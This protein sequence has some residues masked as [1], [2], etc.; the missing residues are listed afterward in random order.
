VKTT[1][2]LKSYLDLELTLDESHFLIV[3]PDL[4]VFKDPS[5]FLEQNS[6]FLLL[7]MN[8]AVHPLSNAHGESNVTGPGQTGSGA[9]LDGMMQGWWRS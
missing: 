5:P 4:T 7:L 2:L 3:T 1:V 6:C 9:R 8:T